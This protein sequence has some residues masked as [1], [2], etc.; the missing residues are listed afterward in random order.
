VPHELLIR[1]KIIRPLGYKKFL[2]ENETVS[3]KI[4][5]F[6]LKIKNIGEHPIPRGYIILELE[7]P[8]GMSSLTE[9]TTPIK[10][11]GIKCNETVSVSA[12]REMVAPGLW[13]LNAT[14]RFKDKEKI[15]YYQSEKLEPD[16]DKW[17]RAFYVVDRHQL[18]LQI[19]LKKLLV[20]KEK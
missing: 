1:F 14:T 19:I 2:S 10:I 13:F 16:Y 20:Q 17:M 18:D 5:R 6:R 8:T 9:S 7:R 3:G 15:A 11:S 12:V 4:T